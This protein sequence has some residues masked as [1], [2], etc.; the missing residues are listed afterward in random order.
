MF[1]IR[2]LLPALAACVVAQSPAWSQSADMVLFNGQVLTVD[3]TFTIH[4]AVAVKDGRILAVGGDD[5]AQKYQAPVRIDLK[6]RT[7]MPGFMDNHLHPG[8]RS[9][10]SVEVSDAKSIAEIQARVRAKAKEL[11]PGEWVTGYGWAETN[12]AEKRNVL[13]ADLDAAAPNNPVA[14]SRAGGHSTVGNSLALKAAGITRDTKNPL[15]GVIEHDAKGEPNGIIRERVDLYGKL[16]PPDTQQALRPSLVAS[17]KSLPTLGITS[18]MVAAASIGDEVKEELRPEQPPTQLTFKMLRSVY[19]EFGTDLPRASVAIGYPGAKALAAYPH[20]TGYGD[21]RL[22]LGPIGE[23]PAVDGGFSGPTAWTTAEYKDNPG[24]HGQPFFTDE[25]DLQT[26][27]D[28]VAKNGWQLGLHAIGDAAINQAVKVYAQALHKYPRQDHRWYLA[29]FTMLPTNAT[30]DAMVKEKIYAAAQPNFLYTLENR[31]LQ[32]LKGADLQ[33]NN[34]VA[35]PL[36]RGVFV[37]FGSDN[38]PI[39]PRVGLY[40]AVT[41]RGSSGTQFGLEEA[42]SIQDA[43]RM[44]TANPPYLTWEEGKKGSLEVGKFADMIVVDVDPLTVEPK[45]LLTMNVDLAIIGGKV[46]HDRAKAGAHR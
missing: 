12:L 20:K 31:Y 35:V 9:P 34:P 42:V 32:T 18:L 21:D 46:V 8:M 19:D 16:V 29:H 45:R 38:L 39:D 25:A 40:A 5:V 14:L 44:Y 26:L 37:T 33:H 13:R 28:D 15:R 2:A 30:L 17:L 27:A 1:R 7:L 10:R 23:A 24:F 4:K 3:E 11:G 43:I 22:R 36:K 6:G 41:R